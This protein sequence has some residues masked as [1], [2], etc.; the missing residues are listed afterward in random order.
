VSNRA[1]TAHSKTAAA[2]LTLAL[3]LISIFS[4]CGGGSSKGPTQPTPPSV[5]PPAP[6]SSPTAA[7][8]FGMQCGTS[9]A[10]DCGG[11]GGVPQWGITAQAQPGF[12][13]LHDAG[14][15]WAGLNPASGTYDFTILGDWLDL[16]AQ[17]EPIQVSQVFI[18]V[19]CWDAPSCSAP[20]DE[21]NG[22]N[23][24]PS[25]LTPSGSPSF[26]SFVTQFVQYCSPGGHCAKDYIKYY[27]MW[28]EW[29]LPVHWTGSPTQLYEMLAPA[30]TII[31]NNVP[32]AVI[33]SPSTS[34]AISTYQTDLSNWLDLEN[35]ATPKLSD[36]VT[37]H[38]YLS[39]SP[40]TTN[41]PET[42][43][44][45]YATNLLTVQ[46]TTPGWENQPWAD[47]ETNFNG[48]SAAV[49][50]TCP[51][52]Y[53]AND[54]TGQIVRWQLLHISFGGSS[55]DW[56]KWNQTIGS[57][58]P[59]E[60]AYFYMMQYIEGGKFT[61]NCGFTTSNGAQVWTCPFTE[62][63]GTT[64]LW[65]WTPTEAGTNY[66]VPSGYTD[67]KDLNGNTTN[68]TAGSSITIGVEPFM[69]EQ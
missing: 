68:V 38:L 24:P 35:T 37:W 65:V 10:Q 53:T 27:E 1:S 48:E 11:A 51:S 58:S 18:W 25:D 17:H 42:Q 67:Y 54:C 13:R 69:L 32:N 20:S 21:P 16:I 62:K 40:T 5:P 23:A 8:S 50:Y 31:R 64:A 46:Q 22:T 45:N 34:P 39:A 14:T 29:N 47:T 30:V 57:N 56:Y 52:E 19:P 6:S 3:L 33:L 12:L 26:N 28:N 7:S 49:P 66:A 63:G 44:A 36:W 41:T 2:G 55:L 43:W 9:D 59:Y 61:A 60:T 15:Y 4:A